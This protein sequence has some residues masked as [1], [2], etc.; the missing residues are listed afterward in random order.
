MSNKLYNPQYG[1]ITESAL[2]PLKVELDQTGRHIANFLN[3]NLV[4][5]TDIPEPLQPFPGAVLPD[6]SG[7]EKFPVPDQPGIYCTREEFISSPKYIAQWVHWK[8]MVDSIL[9]GNYFDLVP[10][11][12]EGIF[13]L[14]CNFLC[15]HCTRRTTRIKWVDKSTWDNNVPVSEANTLYPSGLQRAIDQL[16]NIQVDNQMGIVWGGGDPTSS[17]FTYDGMLYAKSKGITSSFITN[18]VFLDVD[19]C[20]DAEPILIRISLNCGTEKEYRK[21]H[22]YPEGWDYFDRIKQKMRELV[23]KKIERKANTLFG[24]SLIMDERNMSDTIEAAKEIRAVVD[25]SGNGIDY[26]IV[27]PVMQYKHFDQKYTKLDSV[28][29]EKARSLVDNGGEIRNI[30][31]SISIPLILVKDSFENRP[32]IKFHGNGKCLSYG[33]CGEIRHNGDVQLCSDSYGNPKYTIGN[34]F[35]N[36][37]KEI[38]KSDRRRKVLNKVNEEKCYINSC[39]YNSR[40]HH[41]NRIFHKIEQLRTEGRMKLVHEWV[42]DLRK[43]TLPLGHSFFI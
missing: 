7:I 14:A 36:T 37:I 11:H 43:C 28:T 35:N 40:G 8:S 32:P 30:L 15:P 26:V 31:D 39:P 3:E 27:R 12:Y 38:L 4:S 19:R 21:F 6:L 18:G 10:V 9:C 16:A 13:T 34:I 20:L 42:E 17:P 24:I 5:N 23:S 29:K 33:L 25:D 1:T 2:L 22:G 41:H